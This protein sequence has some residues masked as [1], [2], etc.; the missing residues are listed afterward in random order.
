MAGAV[1][2]LFF[3][4]RTT[5]PSGRKHSLLTWRSGIERTQ[6]IRRDLLFEASH[7]ESCL[8]TLGNT[9]AV[10]LGTRLDSKRLFG[11]KRRSI[12]LQLLNV[13]VSLA[14]AECRHSNCSAGNLIVDSAEDCRD[15]S[16]YL[17]I[18]IDYS[19]EAAPKERTWKSRGDLK[20]HSFVVEA[21]AVIC[22]WW[23]CEKRQR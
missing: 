11:Y 3:F 8:S 21:N 9:L 17:E 7:D 2:F 4:F 1:A 13:R 6:L 18:R 23:N 22:L 14:Q 16:Q 5:R 19:S 20:A 10:T 12:W 15:G